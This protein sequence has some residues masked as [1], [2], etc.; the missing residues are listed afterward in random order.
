MKIEEVEKVV[1][2]VVEE[3]SGFY[4]GL[5]D[6]LIRALCLMEMER[7]LKAYSTT[8]L[9]AQEIADSVITAC[10]DSRRRP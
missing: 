5:L 7:E 3:T 9:S 8:Q 10:K 2:R 1:E 4:V 6:F